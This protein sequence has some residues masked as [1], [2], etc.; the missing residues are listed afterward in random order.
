MTRTLIW[1]GWPLCFTCHVWRVMSNS[2]TDL[3]REAHRL[4]VAVLLCSFGCVLAEFVLVAWCHV[5]VCMYMC[6]QCVCACVCVHIHVCICVYLFMVC[7]CVCMWCKC[8]S[9][10]GG[11]DVNVWECLH[12]HMDQ[13]SCHLQLAHDTEYR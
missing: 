4:K 11:S 12:I 1:C 9:M 10:C 8:V 6:M 7:A 2:F 3:Q 5:C 13:A